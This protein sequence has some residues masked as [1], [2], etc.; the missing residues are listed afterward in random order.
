MSARP[1][2]RPVYGTPR[3]TVTGHGDRIFARLGPPGSRIGPSYIV[4]VRNNREVD[5]KLLW[6]R[7]SNDV[8]LPRQPNA[9]AAPSRYAAFEGAPLADARN[10]YVGLTESGTMTASRLSAAWVTT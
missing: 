1:A 9:P 4:A 2:T 7:A 8:D 6:R 5:G 3:Y 10:V